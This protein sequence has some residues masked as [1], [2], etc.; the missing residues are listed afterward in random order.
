MGRIFTIGVGFIAAAIVSGCSTTR[1]GDTEDSASTTSTATSKASIA[2]SIPP[3]PDQKQSS[4]P[5]RF[6]PCLEIGDDLV[7]RA[8]FDPSTRE[9][10]VGDVVTDLLTL[11]GC[12]FNRTATKDGEKVISGSISIESSNRTLDDIRTNPERTAFN[13]DPIRGR[14]AVLYR[15][16]SLPGMCSAAV[17]SPDGVLDV[18]LTVFPGPIA[19]PQPCDQIRELAD[20]FTSALDEK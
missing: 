1:S 15:T 13:S 7:T 19:V 17:A 5:V 14:A 9:R 2:V 10:S 3:P 12:D 11:I 8:G 4:K 18:S 6:D 16:P 20:V